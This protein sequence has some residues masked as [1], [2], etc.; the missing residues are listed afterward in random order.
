MHRACGLR[1]RCGLYYVLVLA[2]RRRGSSGVAGS[3][4][5]GAVLRSRHILSAGPLARCAH[6]A[7]GRRAL[8]SWVLGASDSQ[9]AASVFDAVRTR[10]FFLESLSPRER[11]RFAKATLAAM[12][13]CL[14]RALEFQAG[15]EAAAAGFERLA[16]RGAVLAARARVQW[17][18][19][20][21]EDIDGSASS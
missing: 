19:E 8:R 5:S 2:I 14:E 12:E 9:V 20:V 16:A 1:V 13:S 4:G 3:M 18:R 15:A 21:L 17:M 6:G 11:R 10:A 7:T